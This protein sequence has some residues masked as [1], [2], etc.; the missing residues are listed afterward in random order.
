[1]GRRAS[2]LFERNYGVLWILPILRAAWGNRRLR[3]GAPRGRERQKL[4][5][6]YGVRSCGDFTVDAHLRAVQRGCWA[7]CALGG[8]L[9][10]G[11]GAGPGR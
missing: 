1:V 6:R 4:R 8:P 9:A 11:C 3:K 5:R 2:G 7:A 10:Q